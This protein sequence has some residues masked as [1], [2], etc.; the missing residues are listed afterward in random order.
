MLRYL[1]DSN[2]VIGFLGAKYPRQTLVEMQ[3]IV[4]KSL[5]I[6]IIT[7]IEVLGFTSGLSELDKKTEK[8]SGGLRYLNLR[9]K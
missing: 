2:T 4:D 6:S 9:P 8:L 1:L 5:A 3:K 7:K